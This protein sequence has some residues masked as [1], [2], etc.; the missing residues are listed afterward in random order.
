VTTARAGRVDTVDT[1]DGPVRGRVERALDGRP[2]GVFRGNTYASPPVGAGRFAPPVPAARWRDPLDASRFGPSAPQTVGGALAGLV[3]GM[4]VGPTSED[5]LTLNVWTPGDGSTSTRPAR[6]VMVWFH[7]GAFTI[8]GASLETYDAARLAVEGD[9]V[10]VS[11]NYRLGAL[12]FASV[13]APNCGL[14][15]QVAVLDWMQANAIAFGGDPSNVTVFGESAGAG[16][17]LHLLAAPAARGRFRRA[18][19]Q[20]GATNLTLSSD[21]AAIVAETFASRL[22]VALDDLDA[23]RAA[24]VGEV[25]AAQETTAA[26][27]FASVGMMPFHPVADGEVVSSTPLAAVQSGAGDDIELLIGTTRDEM[28]LFL[29]GVDTAL[30]RDRLVRRVERLVGAEHAGALVAAYERSAEP[31]RGRPGDLWADLMTDSGMTRPAV[32]IADAHATRGRATY[33]YLFT[34]PA[35]PATV[36]LGSCHAIDLPFTF[37]T[38]DREGWSDFVDDAPAAEALSARVRAA[39]CAFAHAGDPGWHAYDAS[40]RA[41]MRLGRDCGT[42]DDPFRARLSAWDDASARG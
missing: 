31:G 39:W 21:A 3:P 7:G 29:G 2:V 40:R 25:L 4:S 33:A 35:A 24:S 26:A 27:T 16:C 8:G 22:G 38:L 12:G 14:L 1:R 11:C 5:C 37:G 34:W 6:P 10:V 23:L 15:D 20:S 30:D 17:I 28:R 36:E 18:I 19:V 9:V 41:T 32:A 42:V 13:D